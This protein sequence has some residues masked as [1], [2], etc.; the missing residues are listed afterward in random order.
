[1]VNVLVVDD[2]SVD[3]FLLKS[4]LNSLISQLNVTFDIQEASNGHEAL[5]ESQ[6][7]PFDIIFMDMVMPELDG[8]EATKEIRAFD[9]NVFIIGMSSTDD[10]E[11]IDLFK[12]AGANLFIG[13]PVFGDTLIS[14]LSDL[15]PRIDST[16]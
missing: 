15:V 12:N 6:L 7:I 14:L 8:I 5:L 11:S 2:L 1:M 16:R 9:Q 13:K 10:P 3:R 4:L